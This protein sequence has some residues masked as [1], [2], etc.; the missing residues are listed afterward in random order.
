MITF[1]VIYPGLQSIRAIETHDKDDDKAW[2]TYWM[3]FGFIHVAET[4]LGF[5]FYF[6]PYWSWIRIALFV[7]LI[8]FNGAQT[9]FET[10][11]RDFLRKNKDLI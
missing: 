8:Q 6:I 9:L 11:L 1:T 3:V 7:W 2:L 5:I 10:V 4:F